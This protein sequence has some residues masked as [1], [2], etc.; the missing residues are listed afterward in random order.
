MKQ[1]RILA[2]MTFVFLLAV[3]AFASDK[4]SVSFTLNH[5]SMVNGTALKP[6][7]YKVVLDRNGDAVQ[8]TFLSGKKTVATTSGHFE[9]RQAF[10]GDVSLVLDDKDNSIQQIL[11]H[12]MKGAVV[13]DNA[14]ATAGGH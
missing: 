6:G 13:L 1:I 14:A 2:S 5:P 4:S 10:A 8:A 9:Q 7:D 12:K 11:V 3:S